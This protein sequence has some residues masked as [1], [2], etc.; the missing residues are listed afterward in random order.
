MVVG[1]EATLCWEQ[2]PGEH[3]WALTHLSR[4]ITSCPLSSHTGTLSG[5]MK[6]RSP[7]PTTSSSST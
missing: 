2:W 4:G 5:G 7:K 3:I 6:H 1:A